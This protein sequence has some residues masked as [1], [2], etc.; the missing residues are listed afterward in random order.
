MTLTIVDDGGASR[1]EARDNGEL[2]GFIDY[3]VRRDRIALIHTET[4]ASYQ[5][6]GI[7]ERLVRFALDDAR[8]RSLR[9]IVI[10]PYVRAFVE[11][12]PETHDIVVGMD[13]AAD[14]QGHAPP[15]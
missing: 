12:H 14:D 1:Y 5:G 4:L 7:A 6:R 3:V 2:A 11:R 13:R 9:V 10:C 8:G 15:A